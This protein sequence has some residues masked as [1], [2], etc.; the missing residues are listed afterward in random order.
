MQ[1]DASGVYYVI[2]NA[3]SS[4]KPKAGQIV[5]VL[6]KGS[7]LENGKVF[8]SSEKMGNKPFDFPLG[9][10]QVIPGWD[11]GIAQLHEGL[12]RHAAGSF[13]AGLRAARRRCRH[14]GRRHPAL[15][16]G[17]GGHEERS[18]AQPAAGGQMDEAELRRQIQAMQQQQQG[19]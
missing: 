6:Y 2:T 11:K 14:S 1:K 19:K 13:V 17:A 15:R 12:E 18:A 3:G 8:D 10:G 4:V 9:Q 7:L 5:S 16:R